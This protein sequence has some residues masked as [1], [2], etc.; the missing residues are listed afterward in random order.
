M[1]Q[2]TAVE[3]NCV[4]RRYVGCYYSGERAM[5]R[6]V[7]EVFDEAALLHTVQG[8]HSLVSELGTLFLTDVPDQVRA[9]REAIERN[10]AAALRFA[11]HAIKGSAATLTAKRVAQCAFELEAMGKDGKLGGARDALQ[12]M[13]KAIDELRERLNS[14]GSH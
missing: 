7:D 13:E 14:T 1:R 2:R 12:K 3:T 4:A 5:E 11:A 9:V 10:D 8:D 6:T